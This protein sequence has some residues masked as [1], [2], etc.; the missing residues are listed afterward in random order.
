MK[1]YLRILNVLIDIWMD[2]YFVG[3]SLYIMLKYQK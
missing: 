3:N 1:E 2:M